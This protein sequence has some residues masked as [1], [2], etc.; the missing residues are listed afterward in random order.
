LIDYSMYHNSN[1]NLNGTIITR[2]AVRAVASNIGKLLMI[3]SPVMGD[4]CFPGGGIEKEE[5]HDQALK[6]E[7]KEECGREIKSIHTKLGIITEYRQDYYC[8]SLK[9]NRRLPMDYKIRKINISN[10]QEILQTAQICVDCIR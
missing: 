2:N 10:Y 9:D 6:R 1:L 8:F 4:Y 5:T 7:L 3:Y